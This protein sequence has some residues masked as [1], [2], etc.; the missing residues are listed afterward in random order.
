MMF[1]AIGVLA[2]WESANYPFGTASR[3]GPG[4]FPTCLGGIMAVL[5]SIVALKAIESSSDAEHAKPAEGSP[6]AWKALTML[7]LGFLLFGWGV[8]RI[9]F[10]PSL[11]ALTVITAAAGSTFNIKEVLIMSV[12]LIAGSVGIF[13]Y[14]VE[15]PIPL[16]W[17]R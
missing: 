8:D 7:S 16:F 14:G 3:M 9:G 12:L 4:Y 17:W 11:F 15:L 6:F 10:I 5:G 2:I 1:L 13:I